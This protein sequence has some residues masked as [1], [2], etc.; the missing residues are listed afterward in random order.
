MWDLIGAIPHPNDKK[1]NAH[2]FIFW[3]YILHHT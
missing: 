1:D 3:V 2:I